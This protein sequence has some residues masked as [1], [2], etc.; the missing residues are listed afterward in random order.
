[1]L[2]SGTSRDAAALRAI[3]YRELAAYLAK[4]V[5]LAEARDAIVTATRQ[6]AKR[7]M[8][9]F[10]KQT[11]AVWFEIES[12]DDGAHVPVY[13]RVLEHVDRELGR[14]AMGVDQGP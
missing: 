6:Y 8:T 10:R 1:M 7:Q 3:G 14:D 11:P 2:D 5:G 4:E 9:W 12:T 13:E